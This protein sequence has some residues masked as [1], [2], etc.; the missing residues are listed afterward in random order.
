MFRCLGSERLPAISAICLFRCLAWVSAFVC[1]ALVCLLITL[2]FI[3]LLLLGQNIRVLLFKLLLKFRNVFKHSESLSS[4]AC[5]QNIKEDIPTASLFFETKR[6]D[7]KTD[8]PREHPRNARV[9]YNEQLG[10]MS[11]NNL[12]VISIGIRPIWWIHSLTLI[13]CCHKPSSTGKPTGSL[14]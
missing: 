3:Q 9:T 8:P 13:F 11:N 5:N 4:C 14:I 1:F 6:I 7:T 12:R 10:T 2:P